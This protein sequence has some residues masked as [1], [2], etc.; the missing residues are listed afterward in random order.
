[1]INE[2]KASN[3]YFSTFWHEFMY[4]LWVRGDNLV[5]NAKKPEYGNALDAKELYPDLKL[6]RLE[7][8]AKE[9]YGRL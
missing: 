4:S 7:D 9:V 2:S 5:E 1:M 8:Y 6:H 3:D